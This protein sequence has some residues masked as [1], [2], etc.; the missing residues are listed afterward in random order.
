MCIERQKISGTFLAPKFLYSQT[1]NLN[2][3]E[4]WSHIIVREMVIYK[5]KPLIMH[6]PKLLTSV[7][8]RYE[9]CCNTRTKHW[10]KHRWQKNSGIKNLANACV[11]ELLNYNMFT[12]QHIISTATDYSAF[13]RIRGKINCPH[14][15]VSILLFVI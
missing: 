14:D 8:Q 11:S 6:Y 13:V 10:I 7:F 9:T 3:C 15:Q 5:T 4:N 2:G 12:P 1:H